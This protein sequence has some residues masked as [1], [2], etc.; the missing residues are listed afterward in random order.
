MAQLMDALLSGNNQTPTNNPLSEQ[1]SLSDQL[2][3][4]VSNPAEDFLV[5]MMQMADDKG[6]LDSSFQDETVEDQYDVAENP[7]PMQFL[8][9]EELTLLVQKFMAIPE[10]LRSQIGE[11]LRQ[12]LPP[13]VAQRLDAVVRFVEGRDGQQQ[14]AM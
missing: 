10:P 9:K 4:L 11:Q 8:S 1:S 13:Q 12:Q 14:V 6:V 7:D 5:T 3:P 2:A